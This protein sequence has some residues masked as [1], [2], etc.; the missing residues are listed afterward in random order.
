M[1]AGTV[2]MIFF[3]LAFET[4]WVYNSHDDISFVVVDAYTE[5][6][7]GLM[8]ILPSYSCFISVTF[9]TLTAILSNS[10]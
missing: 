1:R 8:Y 5:N 7:C 4:T 10:S 3:H 2:K 6:M 9:N